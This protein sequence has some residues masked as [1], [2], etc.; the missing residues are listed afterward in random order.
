MY[1]NFIQVIPFLHRLWIFGCHDNVYS[2]RHNIKTSGYE[3]RSNFIFTLDV[4]TIHFKDY[5]RARIFLKRY[6]K[7]TLK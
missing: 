4:Q 7:A 2:N 6:D 5:K 3:E 1:I